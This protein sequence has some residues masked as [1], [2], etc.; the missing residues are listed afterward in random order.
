MSNQLNKNILATIIYY[1][2]L[3]YPLTAFE[4]WKYLIRTDYYAEKNQTAETSLA[5]VMQNLHDKSLSEY[6]E[7]YNGFY[8]LKGQKSLVERRLRNNKISAGKLKRL[9]RAANWLRYVPFVRMIGVTGALAM[10]NAKAKSDL[11]LLIVL[12]HGKIWTGR[13][14]VTGLL[15]IFG[16]RRHD[17][18]IADRV[19]LNFF[20]TDESLEVITKDLFA[21]SE[22]MFLL[23]LFGREMYERFQIKNQWIKSMKPAYALCEISPLKII[24]DSMISKSIRKIG[25]FALSSNYLE[26][27]LKKMEK[28][29]IMENPKTHQEG[30]M[31]YAND[32][33][34]VFLPSPHGPRLFEEFKRKVEKL[35]V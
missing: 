30:S 34:L 35:S 28:K 12:A 4:V 13:T 6:I 27:C 19:C 29:R 8:F 32:D 9:L 14:L 15:H 22:Y 5:E 20:V 1:D 3:K 26:N 10:K 21:A 18:K 7:S 2:G 23:P 17:K 24:T 11:D 25:E 31:V 33:A 16:Q